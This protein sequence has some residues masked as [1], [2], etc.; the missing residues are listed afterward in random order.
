MRD[1]LDSLGEM[2]A[3]GITTEQLDREA[4]RVCMLSGAECLFKGVPGS[5][6]APP[7]PGNACTSINEEIVHGI[8]GTRMIADGDIVS[9]DFGVKL[10]G[11]CGDAARTY[12][13]G[14]AG[15]EKTRLVEVTRYSLDIA[16]GLIGPG[17]C[18]SHVAGAMSEYIRGEGFSVVEEFVG[19]GIGTKMHEPPKLPNFVTPELRS[20]D[21][22][23]RPGMVLAIEP[24]VNMGRKGVK[25]KSDGWTAVTVDGE[26]SA[27]WEHT[28]AVTETG[29]RVLTA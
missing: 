4:E 1:V 25:V 23:L 20:R 21:I 27:H 9:I 19:H 29:A 17:T 18:W 16:V 15:A 14:T 12:V 8:P 22:E 28:V 13:V 3:P 26:P 5:G 11:W 6:G 24:M 2:V 7:F 10:D